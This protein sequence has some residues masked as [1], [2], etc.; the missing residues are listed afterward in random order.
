MI[1][2]MWSFRALVIFGLSCS[3]LGL[4]AFSF[5]LCHP[6]FSTHAVLMR[7]KILQ[8]W[9]QSKAVTPEKAGSKIN[10]KIWPIP[11]G[12]KWQQS[13]RTQ[14]PKV[15]TGTLDLLHG[16]VCKVLYNFYSHRRGCCK[17][18]KQQVS[19]RCRDQNAS[20]R[21]ICNPLLWF[22]NVV[23]ECVEPVSKREMST[24][25][26][27][28]TRWCVTFWKRI[29]SLLPSWTRRSRCLKGVEFEYEHPL[30][31]LQAFVCGAQNVLIV[32]LTA[33][34]IMIL[35]QHLMQINHSGSLSSI[36]PNFKTTFKERKSELTLGSGRG[37]FKSWRNKTLGLDLP[38]F[39]VQTVED[40]LAH[41]TAPMHSTLQVACGTFCSDLGRA[42]VLSQCWTWWGGNSHT[43]A[44]FWAQGKFKR[45][46]GR[47]IFSRSPGSLPTYLQ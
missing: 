4:V 41:R 34:N 10:W 43:P 31:Q 28:C 13:T 3:W 27:F 15:W 45:L 21:I 6:V 7:R 14:P 22:P 23:L 18:S 32:S 20:M 1:K 11:S 9:F 12:S 25:F 5:L 38:R 35:T 17:G 42:R 36:L 39:V 40:L 37:L 33:L 26:Y 16:K 47:I 24:A 8:Q 2:N 46:W 30:V 44:P 29:C 19:K